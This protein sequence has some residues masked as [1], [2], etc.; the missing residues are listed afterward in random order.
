MSRY[1]RF[2]G[3]SFS[4]NM[5]ILPYHI[6]IYCIFNGLSIYTCVYVFFSFVFTVIALYTASIQKKNLCLD[7]FDWL[8][9]FVVLW[10]TQFLLDK[11]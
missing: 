1:I 8:L 11:E 5:P 4:D 3:S 2:Y 7:Y 10:K 6:P 9:Y